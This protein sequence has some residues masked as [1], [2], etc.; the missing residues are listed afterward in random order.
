MPRRASPPKSPEHEY[1]VMSRCLADRTVQPIALGASDLV[2][3]DAVG[4]SQA[5]QSRQVSCVEV[6]TAYLNHS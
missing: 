5:I 4:L 1:P 6:M 3:M 2:M